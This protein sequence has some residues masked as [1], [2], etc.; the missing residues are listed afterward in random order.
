MRAHQPAEEHDCGEA[1]EKRPP[2]LQKGGPACLG[3]LTNVDE[4]LM[5]G[6]ALSGGLGHVGEEFVCR[7]HRGAAP[8]E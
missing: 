1:V 3:R 6:G 4:E 5:E 7:V 2:H 8:R